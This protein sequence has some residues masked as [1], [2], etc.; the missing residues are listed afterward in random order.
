M[1]QRATDP[2]ASR[3]GWRPAEARSVVPAR[4]P[5]RS[6]HAWPFLSRQAEHA[7]GPQPNPRRRSS[8]FAS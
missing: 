1:I 5:P 7:A 6:G 4:Q 8:D 2:T 3:P